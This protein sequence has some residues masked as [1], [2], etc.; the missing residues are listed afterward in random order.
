[1]SKDERLTR[2]MGYRSAGKNLREMAELEGVSHETIRKILKKAGKDTTGNSTGRPAAEIQV[3]GF[4]G[5]VA[6][7]IKELRAK[8]DKSVDELAEAAGITFNTW[9]RF[10]RGEAIK[11]FG[12]KLDAI[13]AALGVDVALLTKPQKVKE[14]HVSPKSS[15]R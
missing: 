12:A 6:A 10:E 4:A 2:I 8:S 1:M 15:R 11:E 5:I 3:E 14:N 13:A 9:Y 7:R